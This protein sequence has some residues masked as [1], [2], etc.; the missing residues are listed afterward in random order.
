MIALRHQHHISVG[1]QVASLL[2]LLSVILSLVVAC[3]PK[4]P[5]PAKISEMALSLSSTAFEEG[6]RIPVK[7]TCDGQDISPLLEWGEPPQ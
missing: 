2:T 6:D 1:R 4:V 3:S 5:S 7:Y